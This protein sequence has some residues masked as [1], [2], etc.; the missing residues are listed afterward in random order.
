MSLKNVDPKENPVLLEINV[1]P[2]RSDFRLLNKW[3]FLTEIKVLQKERKMDWEEF[4]YVPTFQ[5]LGPFL[6]SFG[7]FF[8]LPGTGLGIDRFS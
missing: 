2:K 6:G 8:I 5:H 1:G 3:Y 7:N 4:F